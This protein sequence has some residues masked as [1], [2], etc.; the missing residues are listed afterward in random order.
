MTASHWMSHVYFKL[1]EAAA[2]VQGHALTVK[3]SPIDNYLSMAN[4]YVDPVTNRKALVSLYTPTPKGLSD[5]PSGVP[6]VGIMRGGP[7][8]GWGAGSAF[9]VPLTG[10]T[11]TPQVMSDTRTV[12]DE[13]WKQFPYSQAQWFQGTWDVIKKSVGYIGFTYNDFVEQWTHWD[14]TMSGLIRNFELWWRILVTVLITYGLYEM[15]TMFESFG[16]IL[17]YLWEAIRT[18]FGL[19]ESILE[20]IWNVFT[21]LLNQ[22]TSVFE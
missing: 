13:V 17:N 10:K 16:R 18:L 14:K 19:S 15:A 1:N 7:G 12:I 20:E 11:Q 22:I 2:S 3:P 21:E 9:V 5:V 4:K 6:K 8:A